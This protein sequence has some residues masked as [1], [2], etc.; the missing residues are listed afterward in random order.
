M[1]NRID[2]EIKKANAFADQIEDLVIA[3]GQCPSGERNTPLMA[4]WSL[5]FDFTEVLYVCCRTSSSDQRS[6]SFDRSLKLRCA[7]M[8]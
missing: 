6:L 5:I 3:K 8:L 1:S 7:L 4:Y 2:D